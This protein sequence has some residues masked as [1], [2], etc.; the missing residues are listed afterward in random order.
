[1]HKELSPEQLVEIVEKASKKFSGQ[2]NELESAVGMLFMARQYG[3]KL[4][5]LAHSKTTVRKYEG[6]LDIRIRDHFPDE[7]PLAHKSIGL[8]IAKKLTNFWK[9]VTDNINGVRN[10][11]IVLR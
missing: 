6:I 8:K 4:M 1:M 3:W 5:Y 9:A 10:A 7:G 2:V 11:E